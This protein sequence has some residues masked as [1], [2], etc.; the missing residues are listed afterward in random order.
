MSTRSRNLVAMLV[1]VLGFASAGFAQRSDILPEQ[2]RQPS[3]DKALAIVKRVPLVPL[4]ED[5]NNPFFP[6]N[7]KKAPETFAPVDESVGEAEPVYRGP[8]NDFE[9][10]EVIAPEINPSG[11]MVLG[12]YPLLLFGQKKVKVGD[13]LPIIYN[14]KRYSLVISAIEGSNFTLK[15]GEAEFTR[16]IKSAN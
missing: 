2:R 12:G 3:V 8:T 13:T 6:N 1:G 14:E 7:L 11:T 15:L 16:P 4:A 5:L 9:L 10:L